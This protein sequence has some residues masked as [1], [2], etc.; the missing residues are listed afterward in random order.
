MANPFDSYQSAFSMFLAAHKEESPPSV[1]TPDIIMFEN[2]QDSPDPSNLS[3][4]NN[5]GPTE[6]NHSLDK[7]LS[8]QSG[9]M[10]SQLHNCASTDSL[11]DQLGER[12]MK[13]LH[14]ESPP[15]SEDANMET[16]QLPS[17]DDDDD[18][19]MSNSAPAEESVDDTP[20]FQAAFEKTLNDEATDDSLLS[21]ELPSISLATNK[22]SVRLEML[23]PGINGESQSFD[24]KATPSDTRSAEAETELVETEDNSVAKATDL[25]QLEDVPSVEQE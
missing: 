8:E 4:S 22:V 11:S 16:A 19:A 12:S 10:T 17:V 9:S 18:D 6:S 20:H 23:P 24:D 7:T 5:S 21:S 13:V 2:S 1:D 14:P 3:Q 15:P 25:E